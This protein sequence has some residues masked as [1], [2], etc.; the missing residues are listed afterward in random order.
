MRARLW[1]CVCHSLR[2]VSVGL[3]EKREFDHHHAAFLQFGICIELN[4]SNY[5]VFASKFQRSACFSARRRI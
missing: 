3:R 2:R 4:Y 1:V 5:Q